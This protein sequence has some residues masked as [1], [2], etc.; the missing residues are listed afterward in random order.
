MKRIKA[1]LEGIIT[2]FIDRCV[3]ARLNAH[4]AAAN[5]A[6]EASSAGIVDLRDRLAKLEERLL[7]Y[8]TNRWNMIDKAVDYLVGAEIPGD[9]FEFGVF[10]GRTFAYAVNTFSRVFPELRFIAVDSFAGL[11]ALQGLDAIG[12]YS[13]SF[14]EGQFACSVEDF[15]N[16]ILEHGVDQTKVKLVIGWFNE[17]LCPGSPQIVGLDKVAVAW[18]DC[19]LYESTVPVLEFL[20]SRISVG[21]LILFDDWHCFRNLGDYGEQR[22]CREWLQRNPQITLNP[23]VDFGFHG[24][25]FTVASC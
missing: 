19:D 6:L 17:S 10:K 18:V 25:S 23:L 20:T 22:A 16:Y 11:P 3:Q 14:H 4:L 5:T 2:P 12:G 9:Y 24:E 13:S 15:T 8:Y 7:D 1:R 21:T